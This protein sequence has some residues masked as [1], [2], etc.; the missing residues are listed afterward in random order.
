MFKD[1]IAFSV[2]ICMH[3]VDS[4]ILL[5]RKCGTWQ[6]HP[7][8][9]ALRG[10][11]QNLA[12]ERSNGVGGDPC[13][14]LIFITS[15]V[16]ALTIGRRSGTSY[17]ATEPSPVLFRTVTTIENGDLSRFK[18]KQNERLP[19]TSKIAMQLI[20]QWNECYSYCE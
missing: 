9:G 11:L 6:G 19:W 1:Q 5:W 16:A 13:D 20:W 17:F 8:S 15:W 18:A 14:K 7:T 3:D 10:M 2:Q 4:L 12:C